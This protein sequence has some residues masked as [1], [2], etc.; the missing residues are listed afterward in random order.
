MNLKTRD[1]TQCAMFAAVMAICAQISIRLPFSP[2]PFTMQ[3]FACVLAGYMLGSKKGFIALII[4][5]LV[6]AFGVPVFAG[7]AGGVS[8]I[9]GPTGGFIIGFPIIA[10][11]TGYA[12][13]KY[14]NMKMII[15]IILIANFIDYALGTAQ[16]MFVM[17]TGIKQALAACV[18]PF[19]ILDIVQIFMAVT[20][21]LRVRK[22]IKVAV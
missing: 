16:F 11:A 21:G 6:G 5:V 10:F 20:I 13:E 18:L 22:V 14:K 12:V 7:L 19:I 3:V 9:T 8:I 17:N 2:V 1:L 4:Y 15:M